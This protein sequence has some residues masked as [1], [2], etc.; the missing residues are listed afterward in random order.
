MYLERDFLL[1]PV[2]VKCFFE[3]LIGIRRAGRRVGQRT[4]LDLLEPAEVRRRPS[5]YETS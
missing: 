2:L 4:A 3:Y 1:I 5:V